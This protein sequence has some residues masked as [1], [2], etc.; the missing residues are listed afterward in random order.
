MNKVSIVG[1]GFRPLDRGARAAVL[2]SDVVLANDR[3]REVFKGYE[4]YEAVKE[5]IIVHGSV[6][7]MLEYIDDHCRARKIALLAAGDPMFFGIGHEVVERT[8]RDSVEVFPDLSSIQVAFARTRETS[9]SALL[10]SLH[11][12]PDPGRRRK[13]EHEVHELPALLER[14]GKLAILTDRENSPSV[15]ASEI[16]GHPASGPSQPAVKMYVC[17][18]LGYAD[19]RVTEGRPEDFSGGDFEH[20]NVV[21]IVREAGEAGLVT[22]PGTAEQGTSA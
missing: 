18:K 22:P 17:E 7:E 10:I 19:E 8:G 20:P 5:R 16:A 13:L 12:G 4:E 6:G 9:N 2:G 11:G 3:L 14:H 1:I 21:I 15:I